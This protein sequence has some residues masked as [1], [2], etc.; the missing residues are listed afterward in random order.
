MI[1][2]QNVTKVFPGGVVAL[3]RVSFTVADGELVV[4]IGL[5]FNR[6]S[7][8]GPADSEGDPGNPS[9]MPISADADGR[10]KEQYQILM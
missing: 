8:A 4:L 9:P 2:F 10:I 1:E 3:D 6:G 7:G 5:G